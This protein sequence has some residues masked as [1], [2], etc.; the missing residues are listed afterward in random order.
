[1]KMNVLSITFFL[2]VPAVWNCSNPNADSKDLPFRVDFD[3]YKLSV[4]LKLSDLIE[5]C[6]LIALETTDES[7]LPDNFQIINLSGDYIIIHDRGNVYKFSS[8]GKF[9]RKV[10][11]NGRG[12]GEI[13]VSCMYVYDNKANILYFEDDFNENDVIKRYDMESEKFLPPIPK[14]FKGFWLGLELYHDSLLM[15][16]IEGVL[17][18][19]TNPYALFIQNFEGDFIEG[20][21]SNRTFIIPRPD[22]T[23]D[24][25]LQR[26]VF[27]TGDENMHVMYWR[28][29]TLFTLKNMQLSPYLV[30]EYNGKYTVPN[31][32]PAEGDTNISYDQS[33]NPCFMFIRHS[34][35]T[36]WTSEGSFNRAHYKRD[37]IILNK[38]TAKYGLIQSYEDDFDRSNYVLGKDLTFKPGVDKEFPWPKTS[39]DGLIFTTYYPTELPE[40]I[41]NNAFRNLAD[42]LNT[43]NKTLKETDNPV[44][45]VGNPRKKLKILN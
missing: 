30:A 36:G 37:Y 1:M 4:D 7:L 8:D 28:D 43:M 13:S 24:E 39:P 32:M 2:L 12:P 27:Y 9:I 41:T 25:V 26:A 33:E 16:S 31:L 10:L 29:D 40:S 14:C 6:R 19:E 45:L 34:T 44:L 22:N 21:K 3:N 38:A 42:Q 15:G 18:G 20:I 23:K 35:F 5:D 11:K 17:R